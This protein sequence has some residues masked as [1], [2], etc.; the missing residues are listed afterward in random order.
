MLIDFLL[1]FFPR[2]LVYKQIIKMYIQTLFFLENELELFVT[3][4]IDI[5]WKD[6][7]R[8][9]YSILAAMRINKQ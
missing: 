9:Q 5:G 7:K 4:P 3:L 1:D 6:A 8:D 2:L